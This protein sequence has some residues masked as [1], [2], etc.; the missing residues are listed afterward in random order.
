MRVA[1]YAPL[2]SPRHPV[3]SGDREMARGLLS[4]LGRAFPGAD[5]ALAS[6]FRSFDGAGD[7]DAQARLIDAAQA[8]GE[9]AAARLAA[10]PPRLWVTYHCHYKA[11]DLIGPAFAARFG[12]PYV[13]VEASRARKRLTGP[14]ARFAAL[15]EAACDAADVIVYLTAR[16]R[17]ALAAHRPPRQRLVALR[18]FLSRDTLPAAAA[19]P[20]GA[21]LCAGMMRPGDKLAS[22]RLAAAALGRLGGAGWT[23]TVAG[24]GPARAEVVDALAP[25]AAQ[26]RHLGALDADGMQ[27]AYAQASI[28]LWPGVNEAFGMV[29]LEAQAAG[30]A[31]V[32]QD[33]PGV[34][35]V[36][37]PG[38]PRPAPETGA[39]G[40]AA[41]LARLLHDPAL[42]RAEGEAA[43]RHVA[44][45]HLLPAAARTL[46]DA[47]APLCAEAAG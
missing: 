20:D 39:E 32:A 38:S 13:L 2:K 17:P 44:A 30:L 19:A 21:I 26:T 40:L 25:V 27:A 33:R 18:P 11:P 41:A 46:R 10:D 9:A 43:R 36:L 7:A 31:V 45:H 14:W 16:D 23:L 37:A 28:L 4:A 34:R 15:S 1:F 8:E 35:E 47:L 42:R 29:Y 3:P 24:D 22:Y 5:I 6:E 12:I